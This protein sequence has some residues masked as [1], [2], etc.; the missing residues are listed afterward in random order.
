VFAGELHRRLDSEEVREVRLE[1][2]ESFYQRLQIVIEAHNWTEETGLR[3]IVAAGVHTV[4]H[5][6]QAE[7]ALDALPVAEQVETLQQRASQLD[8]AYATMKFQ[9][10]QVMNHNEALEMN[11][12]GLIPQLEAARERVRELQAEIEQLRRGTPGMVSP[13]PKEPEAV[14]SSVAHRIRDLLHLD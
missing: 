1:V 10:Y 2:L 6:C 4:E 11:L 7:T 3:E 12:K 8:A 9:A 13:E 14:P 5:W